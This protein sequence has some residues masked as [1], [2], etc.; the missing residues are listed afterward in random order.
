MCVEAACERLGTLAVMR[1]TEM[2]AVESRVNG[3]YGLHQL[4][5]YR[6]GQN[7]VMGVEHGCRKDGAFALTML[8]TVSKNE[9]VS[10][11]ILA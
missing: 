4:G 1:T 6:V 8:Y 7:Q 11:I 3:L 5:E 9:D 10:V 2:K